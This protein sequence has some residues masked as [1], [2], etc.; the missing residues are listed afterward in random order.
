MIEPGDSSA[1]FSDVLVKMAYDNIKVS[2]KMAKTYL[3]SISRTSSESLQQTLG[4]IRAFLAINDSLKLN[5]LEWIF[6]I[7]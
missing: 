2:K 3:K 1:D 7:P 6:G 4:N 5:R